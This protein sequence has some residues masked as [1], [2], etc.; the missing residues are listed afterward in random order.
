MKVIR[1][2]Q[3]LDPLGDICHF[4]MCVFGENNEIKKILI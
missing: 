2:P 3:K 4:L 1:H